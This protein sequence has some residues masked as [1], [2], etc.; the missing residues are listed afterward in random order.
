M[1]LPPW[2][3][4]SGRTAE[5]LVKRSMISGAISPR[6][7]SSCPRNSRNCGRRVAETKVEFNRALDSVARFLA[8]RD[9]SLFELKQ[10]LSRRYEDSLI[11]R[12]LNEAAGRGWLSREED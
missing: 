11:E 7:R 5:S 8:L 3:G 2:T 6:W 12:V 4:K 10:K 1:A 9:H